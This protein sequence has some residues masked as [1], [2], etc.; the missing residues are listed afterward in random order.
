MDNIKADAA[1]HHEKSGHHLEIAA[2]M[3]HDAAKQC[4]SGN[5]EKA[6]SLATSAAEADT[7]A[8]RHAID[9]VDLYRRHA[10]EVADRNAEVAS[11]E[12]ARLAKHKA[13]A[14]NE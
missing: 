7:V 10:E 11:E 8:N 5:Y 6:Q 1:D 3:H 2:K 13:K 14:A 9:A 4:L 12:A